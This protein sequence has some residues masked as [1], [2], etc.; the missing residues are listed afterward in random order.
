M[1][2]NHHL[3]R[4][5]VGEVCDKMKGL[6][7]KRIQLLQI[8]LVSV[9]L[10]SA[11]VAQE[12]D[13]VIEKACRKY[14]DNSCENALRYETDTELD[15]RTHINSNI[16]V[17]KAD[18]TLHGTVT[19]SIIVI[20][21]NIYLEEKALVEG[22]I[23]AINGRIYQED[24]AAVKGSQIETSIKNLF[25]PDVWYK[26]DENEKSVRFDIEKYY[27]RHYGSYSTLPIGVADQS[28]LIRYNSVEGGFLGLKFPKI[29][30]DKVSILN[31]YGFAGYGFSQKRL[32]Y[33][34]GVDRWFF[35]P[36]D[37]RFELG[38]KGFN[39]TER[40]EDWMISP[41]EN[42]L[43]AFFLH[44]DLNNYYRKEGFEVYAKQNITKYFKTSLAYRDRRHH[45][46][47]KNTDWA[48]F[49]GDKKFRENPLINTGHMQTVY[50]EFYLDTR[51]NHT[52]PTMGW[53][54]KL[55]Y[56]TT[57]KG[58]NSAFD[59][60]RYF[61]ELRTYQK[62]SGYDRVD[63]RLMAGSGQGRLP[64]QK[65][66]EL[67]GIGSL[68]GYGFKELKS[69]EMEDNVILGFDRML[70]TNIE[71]NISAKSLRPDFF[72]F[73]D[74]RYILFFDAGSVWSRK[75]VSAENS[76]YKG[77]SHLSWNHFASD[78]GIALSTWSG[79]ARLNFAKRLDTGKDA[80]TI[81]FRLTKPF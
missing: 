14:L 53:Y 75:N 10:I 66:F 52:L 69:T 26:P 4:K 51:N 21:G 1:E 80:I 63:L 33:E 57:L 31:I 30:V 78:L 15:D 12:N 25:P 55:S 73:D 20:S 3:L 50:G 40:K 67:G 19:G 32:Q 18:L 61:F 44:E 22:D 71:Y 39:Y 27:N 56:E 16:L 42:T 11:S 65:S 28:L 2:L 41:T 13:A 17:V 49:G 58:S 38:I 48:L 29:I 76:W 70:L 68:R 54:S 79:K 5:G 46:V 8:I 47:N 74:V 35:S 7:V 43:A 37:Y 45:N 59:F 34:L 64:F 24:E 60:S 72:F 81:T 62:L 36:V 23:V 9:L 77:F 6:V